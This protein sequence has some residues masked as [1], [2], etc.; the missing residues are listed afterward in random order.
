MTDLLLPAVFT[1]FAWWFSTGAILWLD[2]LPRNTFRVSITVATSLAA[3]SLWALSATADDGS[4]SG[5]YLAFLAGLMIW[6]WQEMT[7]LMGFI[8]GPRPAAATPGAGPLRRFAEAT[9][10][11]LHH[12]LAILAGAA[13]IAAAT[14]GGENLAGLW[15]Y[16]LLWAMR[17][18]AKLNLFLGVPN[19]GEELLPD[20]LAFLKSHFRRRP[21]NLLFPFSITGGTIGTVL[22]VQAA[23]TATSAGEAAGYTFLASMLALAVLEHWFLVLPI[24]SILL[25]AWS[26]RDAARKPE[27]RDWSTSIDAPCDPEGL[28]HLLDAA[29]RGAFGEVETLRGSVRAGGGWVE[30]YASERG[31]T[32]TACPAPPSAEARVTATGAR[33]D[34][35]R[36]QAALLACTAAPLPEAG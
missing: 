19:S 23:L 33:I 7:F 2:G 15:T 20:H 28:R 32:I 3:L 11:I 34:L 25:W 35:K 16:L 4:L 29:S 9:A 26:L 14:W 31:A 8:T 18:S 13:A 12:E 27:K 17:L 24:P 10:A 30:F 1:A 22:L 36:L 6:A 21:M 5:A